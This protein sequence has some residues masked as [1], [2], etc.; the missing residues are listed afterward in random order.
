[1]ILVET[2]FAKLWSYIVHL[3]FSKMHCFQIFA[4]PKKLGGGLNYFFIFTAIPGEIIQFDE[5]ILSSGWLNHQLE[6]HLPLRTTDKE[7]DGR[8]SEEG[9]FN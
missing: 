8:K 9:N 6:I 5:H 7:F 4:P 2:Q 1:M 3:F